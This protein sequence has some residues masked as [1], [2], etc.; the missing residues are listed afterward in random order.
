MKLR[1]LAIVT[2][3]VLSAISINSANSL[4]TP[5][6]VTNIK[7]KVTRSKDARSEEIKYR[8]KVLREDEKYKTEKKL[9]ERRPSGY[10]TVDEY[11]AL[12]EYK[13]RPNGDIGMP[14]VEVPSD[15][16]YIPQP[17]YKIVLYNDPP[18]TAELSLGKKLY[19]QRQINAQGIVS[20]DYTTLVYPAVYYYPDSASTACDLFVVP[21]N[22]A[23][24]NLN[25]ILKANVAQRNP[26]PILSTEKNIE[27]Y[28]V[29]RTLTPVDFSADGSKLLI[30]EKIGS[31][32]DGIWKTKVYV[33][34]F[35]K[36]VDYD[37]VEI[38]DAITYFWKEYMAVNLDDLRWD[39][40]PLGFAQSDDSRII[41]Q[42]Y[43]YTGE[44]PIYLGAW[45]VDYQGNQSRLVSFR[46]EF[47]PKVSSNG[48]KVIRDGVECY[49]VVEREEEDRLKLSERMAKEKTKNDRKEVKEI[50]DEYK[51]NLK[52][53]NERYKEDMNSYRKL[54]KMSGATEGPDIEEAFK[55]YQKDQLQKDIEKTEKQ[56]EKI[57]KDIDKIDEKLNNLKGNDSA[58][59]EDLNEN[60]DEKQENEQNKEQNEEEQNPNRPRVT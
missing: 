20:P 1:Y 45:S 13:G 22:Q 25:R 43:G 17:L 37:L 59:D 39:V 2:G 6:F 38:R 28:A 23:E 29:F 27:N 11:E 21:L 41:V 4:E 56:I 3:I 12:S 47:T 53:L 60:S 50:L 26:S 18:G 24:T 19:N 54:Q 51:F 16:K 46:R 30:K 10:M 8:Y 40:Y 36:G 32:E 34:D 52:V 15:F 33:Y 9:L 35:A 57:Q 58:Q 55:Q 42:A 14:K 49:D 44:T 31:S 48:F 7:E 5:E